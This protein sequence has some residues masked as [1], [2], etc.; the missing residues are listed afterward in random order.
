MPPLFPSCESDQSHEQC[1]QVEG[2]RKGVTEDSC[3][4][5]GQAL[6]GAPVEGEEEEDGV[7]EEAGEGE[8]GGEELQ[9]EESEGQAGEEGEEE[10]GY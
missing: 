7:L 6:T 5:S 4:P 3:H 1:K 8:E 10:A 2:G 9:G